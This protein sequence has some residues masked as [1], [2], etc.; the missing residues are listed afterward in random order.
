MLE[1]YHW[2]WEDIIK[3]RDQFKGGGEDGR[4][5]YNECERWQMHSKLFFLKPGGRSKSRYEDNIRID[6]REIR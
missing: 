2:R 5:I 1:I 6:L 4:V 3:I